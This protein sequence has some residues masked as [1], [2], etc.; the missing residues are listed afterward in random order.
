MGPDGGQVAD[1]NRIAVVRLFS[2]F[3]VLFCTGVKKDSF[4]LETGPAL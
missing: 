3:S 2:A 1:M 4:P